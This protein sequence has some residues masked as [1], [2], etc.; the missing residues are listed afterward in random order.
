MCDPHARLVRLL[1]RAAGA[2]ATLVRASAEPW[3]SVTFGGMRHRL[4]FRV[5]AGD[6]DRLG[7]VP[8]EAITLPGHLLVDMGEVARRPDGVA[9]VVEIDALTLEAG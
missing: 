3:I 4:A 5:A 2:D 9:T 8:L 7:Q 1:A 6:A